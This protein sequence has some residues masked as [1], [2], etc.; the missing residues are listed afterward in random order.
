MVGAPDLAAARG[1]DALVPVVTVETIQPADVAGLTYCRALEEG[2]ILFFPRPPFDL[3]AG[4]RAFLL[5]QRQVGA[6]YHK[7]I[8]YRPQV[9]RVSGFVKQSEGD[10]DRLREVLR[11]YS[12]RVTA[13]A[14]AL[15]PTY[16]R[17]WRVDFASFRP[18]EEAGRALPQH[19]RNDL[20]H[21]DAFPTRPS[22]GD[23][24]LRVFTNISPTAERV[25]ITG[26]TFERLA[27]RFAVASG[28]LA[29]AQR[30]GLAGSLR[31]L[32]RGLGLPITVRSPYDAF[33]MGFH[34]F[35]K[36]NRA[37]QDA[38]PKERHVF[39]PGSTWLVLTD[40]VSHAVLAGQ[41]A[42]EQTFII[43]RGSLALPEKAPIEI[44][45]RIARARL[46]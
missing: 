40:M 6:G 28:L 5:T 18:Q 16:A 33:M 42:L 26:D 30:P 38:A 39:P 7:N 12:R 19:A 43:A 17:G 22:H 11:D 9:D 8:A 21:V 14:A 27:D 41:F 13:F 25:W 32:A 4:D 3:P 44:L 1:G 45:E 36:E 10:A 2:R 31:R 34:H 24:I 37:C 29:R 20:L 23:R 46:A 15:L 35:M